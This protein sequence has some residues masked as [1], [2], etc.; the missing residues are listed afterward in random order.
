VRHGIRQ[1]SN[2]IHNQIGNQIRNQIV[3]QIV[4][5]IRNQIVNQIGNRQI[6]IPSIRNRQIFNPQSAI[7]NLVKLPSER[8][9][10]RPAAG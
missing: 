1:S 6:R 5:Q 10:N 8:I 9:R 7:C 2:Q 4:N 3:N